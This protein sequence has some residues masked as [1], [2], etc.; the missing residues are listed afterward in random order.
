MLTELKETRVFAKR[1]KHRA[2]NSITAI[3]KIA[4]PFANMSDPTRCRKEEIS[5]LHEV[6]FRENYDR[7][8]KRKKE[9]ERGRVSF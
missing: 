2:C 5:D 8:K 7:E 4:V 9:K 3:Y 6:I 1:M